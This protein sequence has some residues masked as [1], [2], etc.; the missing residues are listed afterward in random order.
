MAYRS[1]M[2]AP[3]LFAGQ[4]VLVTG[5]GT[6]IGLAAA[7]EFAALGA[8]VAIAGRSEDKLAAGRAALEADGAEPFA[9]TCDIREPEGCEA[10]VDAV[11]G[12]FGRLDV[13]VNNAGGQ[14]PAPAAQMS[15]KGFDAVVRNNLSGTFYMTRAAATRA[16]LPARRGRV[17]NVIANVAR[18]FP[19]MAHTG[20]ARAGVDNL[21]K[22]LALEWAPSGL[23]VNAVAPGNNIRSSGT[24]QYGEALLEAARRATPLKRLGTPEEVARVIVF[25]SSDLNDYVTGC[26]YYVDG[27]QALWGDIWPIDEPAP[28]GAASEP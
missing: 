8:R 13:L 21:T 1:P 22:S 2:F 26:T 6:G 12:R 24:A 19:G 20:A 10:L 15:P 16:M 27:G 14:F 11:L 4:V 7:R 18:G 17:V 23:R 9:R 3:G 5:G 25:L 28:A